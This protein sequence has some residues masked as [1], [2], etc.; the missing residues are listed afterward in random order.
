[1]TTDQPSPASSG[2][3]HVVFGTGPVGQA[4]VTTLL[5]RG[6]RVR[7][8]NRRGHAE[9]PPRVERVAGDAADAAFTTH[10]CAGASVV[11][12]ALN[13]PYHQWPKLFPALQAGVLQGV[14]AAG[15]R[16]VV[17][18]NLYGYGPAGGQPFTEDHPLVATTRKGI[19]RAA[20]TRDLLTAHQRGMVEVAIGRASGFFGPGVR[21]SA[22]G[23]RVFAAVLAGK[24]V[25]VAGDPNLLHT[26]TYIEDIGRALVTLGE[27]D[28]ALGQVW[29]IPSPETISTRQFVERIAAAAGT[30]ARLQRV[31][32][33]ALRGVGLFN[34]TVRELVEMLYEFEAPF[35]VDHSRY[36]R[37][38]GDQA[39]PLG[40]AISRTLAWY[41]QV[42]ARAAA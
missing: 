38:F 7:A 18:E 17:I 36:T 40:E 1:M 23:E 2:Q 33:L 12:N 3:L 26:Y 31:P 6:H 16:L 5:S 37:A 19:T 22:L 34:P 35:V 13:P 14:A 9:L 25:Q 10:A 41:Q 4:I 42:P 24:R 32:A 15:A 30:R 21:E 27:H 11:Y 28:E 39:T 8:V 20:M 29:H